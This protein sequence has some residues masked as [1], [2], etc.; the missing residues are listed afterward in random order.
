MDNDLFKDDPSVRTPSNVRKMIRAKFDKDSFKDNPPDKT[1]SNV[2]K[3]ISAFESSLAQDMK[4]RVS[5][6]KSQP[7]KTLVEVASD[8]TQLKEVKA[9][10]SKPLV[11]DSARISSPLLIRELQMNQTF[12][13]KTKEQMETQRAMCEV[14]TTPT[15]I[16][17]EDHI[18]S[19]ERIKLEETCKNK[20]TD[21]EG[22]SSEDLLRSSINQTDSCVNSVLVDK[23]S[24]TH[25]RD[26]H[27]N[28]EVE[29]VANVENACSFESSGGW[30]FPYDAK[31]LCITSWG[32][33][34]MDLV[35]IC[36]V[37]AQ[38]PQRIMSSA[39]PVATSEHNVHADSNVEAKQKL[40]NLKRS[41]LDKSADD[42]TLGNPVGQAI[43]IAIMVGFG[44]LVLLTRKRKTR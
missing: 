8:S 9:E 5:L 44:I 31:G 37:E 11:V 18:I 25:L 4:P 39:R 17:L 1:P 32:K 40:H 35:G 13:G 41:E 28:F 6:P 16:Q 36:D 12:V 38:S 27:E 29:P 20:D 30:I 7:S 21:E 10:H 24:G 3:M 19:N 15:C 42:E 23:G 33:K 34:V 22:E 26:P 43:N 2:R 14:K